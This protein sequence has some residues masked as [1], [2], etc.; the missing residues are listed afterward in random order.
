M[1]GQ[2]VCTASS[3]KPVAWLQ[4]QGTTVGSRA[5]SSSPG[6]LGIAP[7]RAPDLVW[8][9]CTKTFKGR[10]L[11]PHRPLLVRGKICMILL[12]EDGSRDPPSQG[13]ARHSAGAGRA[14][15]LPAHG[16]S[17][18]SHAGGPRRPWAMP[19]G[20]CLG[21]PPVHR[22]KQGSPRAGGEQGPPLTMLLQQVICKA[23]HM[24]PTPVQD[25][26][27][28]AGLCDLTHPA[29]GLSSTAPC[30]GGITLILC[31]QTAPCIGA[32]R[33]ECSSQLPICYTIMPFT[34]SILP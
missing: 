33:P 21:E 20:G 26:M 22:G 23:L 17:N 9:C 32:H 5:G 34:A 28:E 25:H 12:A 10:M 14:A 31:M 30:K 27:V 19:Q 7:W 6:E 24:S 1:P 18:G 16:L 4:T 15:R 8:C 11:L 3:H 29:A 13:N 2:G